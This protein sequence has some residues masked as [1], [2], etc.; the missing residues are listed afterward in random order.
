MRVGT[1][2]RRAL[3]ALLALALFVASCGD[4]D[5]SDATS[6]D[7]ETETSD[8]TATE[9]AGEQA[10]GGGDF[11]S[12]YQELLAGD[13]APE[14]IRAVADL[15][16][17]EAKDPLETLA[18]GFESDPA[19]Y[20]ETE[21]FG[22]TFAQLGG[23]VNE[24]CADETMSVTAVDYGFEGIPDE[25][26]PGTYGV[27]LSNEGKEFHEMIVVRKAEGTTQSFE[28]ILALDQAQAR[29][30]AIEVGATFAPP[31]GNG[32]GLFE[33]TEPGDYAAVCFIPVGSTPEAEEQSSGP[34][35]FTQGMIAEFSVS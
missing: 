4:D 27:E 8:D 16:P 17:D 26:T 12:A 25:L 3:A 20:S 15:A 18:A 34:P 35:H 21:E 13:P 14:D 6:A 9:G 7:T 10:A 32:G 29:E 11:C 28:E 1:S 2:Q 5:T 19:G 30:L 31:G 23:I 22:T 33:L 24:E